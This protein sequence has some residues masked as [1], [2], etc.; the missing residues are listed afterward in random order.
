M[1]AAAMWI[2]PK[3]PIAE[4]MDTPALHTARVTMYT[5][6]TSH[7]SVTAPE[8]QAA[9]AQTQRMHKKRMIVLQAKPVQMAVVLTKTSPAQQT[10][11]VAPMLLQALRSAKVIQFTKTTSHTPATTRAHPRA[12]VLILQ[13]HN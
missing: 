11:T 8:H 5:R 7:I 12:L 1:A 2:A 6:T 3:T 10:Q 13:I 9:I 4:P